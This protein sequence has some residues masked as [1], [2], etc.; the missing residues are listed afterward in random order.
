MFV[1][2]WDGY[3]MQQVFVQ[4]K[5]V[6][7]Q[8]EVLVGV[9]V[10]C[11]NEIVGVGYNVLI[12]MYDLFVYVEMCVLCQVVENFGNYCLFDC[13]VFVILELCVMCVGVMLYV[14]VVCVV[15]GVF[16]FKMG[17]VGSI[18]DLFVEMCL[19]YQIV[20]VGSVFVQECGDML[21]V[22]FVEC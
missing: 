22:F 21:C 10:V 11:G 7:G 14:C 16:D 2:E 5:F 17:V 1:Y 3:W 20:I 9:V 4:V 8:G 12:G 13:E 18:F 19:N 6:W 15:Y